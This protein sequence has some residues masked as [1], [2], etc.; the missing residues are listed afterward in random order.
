MGCH[1]ETVFYGL[2]NLSDL[3]RGLLGVAKSPQSATKT[4]DYMHCVAWGAALLHGS[5]LDRF[6]FPVLLSLGVGVRL[7]SWAI[8]SMSRW[9]Q[10]TLC[11]MNSLL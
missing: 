9:W 2:W 8:G 4:A 6:R 5:G 1:F 11:V 7:G 3:C 10:S